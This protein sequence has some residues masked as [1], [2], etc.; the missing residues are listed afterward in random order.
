MLMRRPTCCLSS[1]P[2]NC[3]SLILRNN[4]MP[5]LTGLLVM[6]KFESQTGGFNCSSFFPKNK[7][8]AEA[9]TG[10]RRKDIRSS[11]FCHRHCLRPWSSRRHA[12]TAAFATSSRCP[13]GGTS[14]CSSGISYHPRRAFVPRN[15]QK[16]HINWVPPP[17][18]VPNIVGQPRRFTTKHTE[19]TE[20]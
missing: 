20:I 6:K 1:S 13:S 19:S 3:S 14:R 10:G 8:L 5:H 4:S 9:V 18:R 7:R 2:G 16:K 11:S 12:R 17:T 15:L